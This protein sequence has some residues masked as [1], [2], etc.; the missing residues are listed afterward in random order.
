M[1]AHNRSGSARGGVELVDLE[2]L[3][4]ES[5]YLVATLPLTEDT[6]HLLDADRIGQMKSTAYLINIGRGQTVDQAALTEALKRGGIAGA[7]LDVFEREPVDPAD[8]LL[9]MD[10]VIVTPH[11]IGL[12]REMLT[13]VGRSACRSV[14]AV[15]EGRVPATVINPR[16][17]ERPRLANR[18]RR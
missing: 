8:P 9:T 13:D 1:I 3:L 5:D 2:T 11:A 10:N 7:A 6:H 15:A 12:T 18:L 14:L 16:A 17:L 4:R